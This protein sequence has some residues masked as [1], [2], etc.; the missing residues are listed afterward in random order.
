[1]LDTLYVYRRFL[2]VSIRAQMQYK[3]SFFM[4]LV[5][6]LIITTGELMAI[7]VLFGRFG[8]LI[9]WNVY[10]VAFIYGIVNISFAVADALTTGFDM[11][12]T[13]VKSGDFDRI[14]TRPRSTALQLAGARIDA[15]SDQST[16]TGSSGFD[17]GVVL[18]RP[19]L[20]GS[21]HGFADRVGCRG[22]IFVRRIDSFTGHARVLDD[23]NAGDNERG[24]LRRCRDYPVPDQHL[25]SVVP[26]LLHIWDSARVC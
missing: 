8:S 13:M 16:N 12:G 20:D 9:G 6:R 17:L 1:M 4:Q 21:E 19:E 26:E 25:S 2:G 7:F 14:L 23:R 5:G 3:A 24:Y 11:F 10:Q 15:P 18:S 22:S